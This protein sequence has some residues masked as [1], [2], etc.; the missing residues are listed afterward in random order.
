MDTTLSDIFLMLQIDTDGHY[1]SLEVA[2]LVVLIFTK[3]VY[4]CNF[5]RGGG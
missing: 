2:S 1:M 3:A 4:I 5:D